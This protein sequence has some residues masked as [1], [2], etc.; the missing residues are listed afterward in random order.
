MFDPRARRVLWRFRLGL[1][2]KAPTGVG[3]FE[4]GVIML[5][6]EQVSHPNE[7]KYNA[8]FCS[9]RGCS[10]W[11]N[12]LLDKAIIDESKL[13][14]VNALDNN[15]DPVDLCG[16][17]FSLHPKAI[18]SLGRVAQRQLLAQGITGF[19]HVHHPQYWKRFKSKQ[20]YPLIELL[21]HYGA[22]IT[23]PNGK[24]L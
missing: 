8:P 20:P 9:L 1:K 2:T 19:E 24:P 21:E 15:G 6:G 3:T 16:L 11:L 18:I 10:G 4:P 13:Y 14:W 23:Y 7:T 17:V 22:S 5:V 12:G